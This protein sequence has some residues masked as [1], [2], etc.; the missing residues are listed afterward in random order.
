MDV[1]GYIKENFENM[2]I[3]EVKPNEIVFEERVKLKCFFCN[4]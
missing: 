2:T 3:Y 4:R 1:R